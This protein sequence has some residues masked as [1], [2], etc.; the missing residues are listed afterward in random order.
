METFSILEAKAQFSRLLELV[1]KGGSFIISDNGKPVAMVVPYDGATVHSA[2][3]FGD[4]KG[5]G[6]A[7]ASRSDA[8]AAGDAR[9]ERVLAFAVEIYRSV[10]QA[11]RFLDAPHMMLAGSIPLQ[12]ARESDEGADSVISL[13]GRAAY[14]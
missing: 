1:A 5:Q 7:P 9:V 10:E 4:V 8:D 6:R 13:L 3:H 12:R 11:R 14:C 2:E